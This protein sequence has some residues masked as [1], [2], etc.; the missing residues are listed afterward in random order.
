MEWR[1]P[2]MHIQIKTS[3]G[4][5]SS[6]RTG[7]GAMELTPIEVD[8]LEVKQGALLELL[9]LLAEHDYDLAMAGGDSIEAGGEF[10]FALK[11]N[12]E[13]VPEND[14]SGECAALLKS[15]GYRNVRL[16]EPHVCEAEDRVGG[17]RD[18]IAELVEQGRRIDEIYVGTPDDGKIPIHVTSIKTV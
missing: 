4:T 5:A 17:L 7:T 11:H 14:R 18:C 3:L 8:P 6:T 15:N 1:R 12:D 16:I 13:A 9:N 10:V 2:W